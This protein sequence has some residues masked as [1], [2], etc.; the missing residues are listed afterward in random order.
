MCY[1]AR[2]NVIS[3]QNL[4]GELQRPNGFGRDQW[5]SCIMYR[6]L[7]AHLLPYTDIFENKSLKHAA[8]GINIIELEKVSIRSTIPIKKNC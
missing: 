4:G 8:G 5:E 7:T 1:E 3:W 2:G 6:R